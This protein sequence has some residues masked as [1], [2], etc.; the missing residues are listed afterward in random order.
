MVDVFF[1][2][3]VIDGAICLCC[4]R[5]KYPTLSTKDAVRQLQ[6]G[7]AFLAGYDY[8]RATE[9]GDLVGWDAIVIHGARQEQLRETL[10]NLAVKLKPFWARISHFGRSRVLQVI[11]EDQ[12]QCL[13]FAGLLAAPPSDAVVTWWDEVGAYFRAENERRNTEIGREGERRT[14][15]YETQRLKKE[16]I[17]KKPSWTALD[18]ICAG[19]DVHSFQHT[20]DKKIS[21]LYIEVKA[22]S[23]SPTHFVLTRP[24]WDT[25]S[26]QPNLH[27]FHI[28]NLETAELTKITVSDMAVHI[29]EDSGAGH[30]REVRITLV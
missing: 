7:P 19:Y 18:D 20:A 14:M 3:S 6:N 30:W 27:L 29:P 5:Q 12:R 13:E 11:S 28:W 15:K 23:Y 1:K 17:P 24:E 8:G 4:H 26:K 9:L 21:D 22:A 10:K 16:G 25:A 2:I